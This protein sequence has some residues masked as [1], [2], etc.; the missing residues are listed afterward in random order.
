MRQRPLLLTP[1]PLTTAPETRAA[2][3]RDWGS[4]DKAFTAMTARVRKSVLDIA[5]AGAD[6]TCILLQG[7]GT[8]AV[9]SAIGTLLP[10]DGHLMVLVNGAYGQRMIRL[11]ERMG[12]RVSSLSWPED[13]AI[14]AEKVNQTLAKDPSITHVAAVYCETTSGLLNPIGEIAEVVASRGRRLFIDAMSAFGALP[15]SAREVP[16]D[17]IMA[18]SNKCIEG[19]P[20]VGLVVARV[21]SLAA[22]EG[23]AHS[24]SLD[25]HDQWRGLEK[26]G[27]WRFTPPTQVLAAFDAALS[28]HAQEGGVMGRG[29]RYRENCRRLVM[30]MR[31]LGFHTFL[32]DS[33]QAPIIVTFHSPRD[34]AFAFE[35][36]YDALSAAG[37]IIYPGKLT[38]AETFRMGCIGQVHP[39]DIDEAVAAVGR[40]IQEMGVASCSP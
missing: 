17:A 32:P 27:Q 33:L 19:V 28:A 29:G 7:S 3:G 15:L 23:N 22:S 6:H 31:A 4:R 25:L 9:E 38:E 34:P 8:F 37:F 30:G 21:S 11:T 13:Q 36:L 5:H 16:F 20:G 18:S 10:R 14:E 40:V 39:E 12:R 35:T 26:N 24:V 1:G 2:L